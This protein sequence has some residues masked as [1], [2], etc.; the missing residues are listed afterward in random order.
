MAVGI[1]AVGFDLDGTLYPGWL[2]YVLSIDIGL[3]HPFLLSA[4]GSAR[5]T[6]RKGVAPPDPRGPTNSDDEL[7]AFRRRQSALVSKRLRTYEVRVSKIIDRLIYSGVE[8]K[9]KYIRP[10]RGVTASLDELRAS[11]LRLGI[12]SDLPPWK[13][14]EF[15]GL[16]GFFDAVLCSEHSG[17][18]KPDPR[19]FLLLAENLGVA[20]EEM[21]YV[22]NKYAYDVEG[23][24][25]AGMKTALIGRRK[26]LDAADFIFTRW[27]DL[28][29]W[30]KAQI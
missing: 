15:L 28:T 26:N 1:K 3:R 27:D 23:A 22:G 16:D 19:P 21:L 12:L 10:Y 30:V 14:L 24:R 5:K 18:L 11:G 8:K 4:Y 17:V 13:K 2:L 7:D 25:S 29:R 9:F 20:P 6:L